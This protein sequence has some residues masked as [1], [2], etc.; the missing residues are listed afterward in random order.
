MEV[1]T[2]CYRKQGLDRLFHYKISARSDNEALGLFFV[3]HPTLCLDCVMEYG[4][5]EDEKTI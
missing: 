5:F 3:G 1:Y 2:I 4:R